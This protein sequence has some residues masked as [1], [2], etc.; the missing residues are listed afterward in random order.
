[1]HILVACVDKLQYTSLFNTEYRV[2]LRFGVDQR[3]YWCK[4]TPQK[5][6]DVERVHLG[7]V[8]Y[9]YL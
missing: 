8:D 4:S 2:D 6:R 5:L 9:I 1:M 3:V 7:R